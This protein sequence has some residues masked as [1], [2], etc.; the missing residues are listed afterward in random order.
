MLPYLY[1][2]QYE[3]HVHRHYWLHSSHNSQ[4]KAR[5]TIK[6]MISVS[7]SYRS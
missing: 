1:Q 4:V 6:K 5:R 3:M 7:L 2:L